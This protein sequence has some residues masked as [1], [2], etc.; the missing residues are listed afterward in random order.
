MTLAMNRNGCLRRV[1][2]L[3]HN[4]GVT[5][6]MNDSLPGRLVP[7]RSERIKALRA[8]PP[9]PPSARKYIARDAH[10]MFFRPGPGGKRKRQRRQ[11]NPKKRRKT[12]SLTNKQRAV[13]TRAYYHQHFGNENP[14]PRQHETPLTWSV[15]EILG[16]QT[17]TDKTHNTMAMTPPTARELLQYFDDHSADHANLRDFSELNP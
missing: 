7:R 17:T 5:V 14:D 13:W 1:H 4:V 9:S 3:R 2:V 6:T 8:P 16:H 10:E 12:P 11:H 15:P